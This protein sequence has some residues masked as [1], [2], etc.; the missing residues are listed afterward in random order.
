[1]VCKEF[2]ESFMRKCRDATLFLKARL[3]K[4]YSTEKHLPFRCSWPTSQLPLKGTVCLVPASTLAV[5]CAP[6][7]S[8]Q[9]Q[10][11]ADPSLTRFT[12]LNLQVFTSVLPSQKWIKQ[13]MVSKERCCT[14][15]SS[16]NI[17]HILF[18]FSLFGNSQEAQLI[19]A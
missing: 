12:Q 15:N 17:F 3:V 1:M 6:A 10:I 4:L 5:C 14:E 2:S 9:E 16:E 18:T 7:T 19:Y 13:S 8:L 11:C